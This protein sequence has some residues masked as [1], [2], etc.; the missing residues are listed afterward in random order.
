[1]HDQDARHNFK[2]IMEVPSRAAAG[3]TG[4]LPAS[5]AA[6]TPFK[7]AVGSG[8]A[9]L[10]AV[11]RYPVEAGAGAWWQPDGSPWTGQPLTKPYEG[12]RP[13]E[14]S[15]TEQYKFIIRT[16]GLPAGA[17]TYTFDVIPDEGPPVPGGGSGGVDGPPEGPG[18]VLWEHIRIVPRGTKTAAIRMGLA[19]EPWKTL[20]AGGRPLAAETGTEGAIKFARPT[21]KNG[22]ASVAVTHNV[23]G[24]P[25]RIVAVDLGGVEHTWAGSSGWSGHLELTFPD[26]P[27]AE[28]K[29]FRFQTRPVQ[30]IDFKDVVLKPNTAVAGAL[31]EAEAIEALQKLGMSCVRDDN[32]PGRPVTSAGI[33]SSCRNLTDADLVHLLAFKHLERLQLSVAMRRA[34]PTRAWRC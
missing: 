22:A 27:L 19:V 5:A 12:T 28:V 1:M 13:V 32:A 20:A 30:W 7:A 2:G 4:G 6:A 26:L 31:A 15:K 9:Q 14:S 23:T 34:S 16:A 25:V 17:E 18:I 29:E 33:S 24:Q 3:A 11:A 10:V 8:S 21:E